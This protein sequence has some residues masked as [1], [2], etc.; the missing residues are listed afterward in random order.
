M[1]ITRVG[2]EPTTFA[3]LELMSGVDLSDLV[4]KASAL[5]WVV[6]SNPTQVIEEIQCFTRKCVGGNQN[7]IGGFSV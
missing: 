5:E 3:I 1:H 4:G 7:I 2:F 6:G